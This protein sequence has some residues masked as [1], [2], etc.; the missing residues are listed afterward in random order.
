MSDTIETTWG[1]TL[2]GMAVLRLVLVLWTFRRLR[3][4]H[5]E[6]Y[7]AIGEPSLFGNNNLRTNWLFLKFLYLN[8][9]LDLNDWQLAC[10]ARFMQVMLVAYMIGFVGLL[11]IF[12]V[13]RL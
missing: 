4:H 10:V 3:L 6:T 8:Q 5:V 12:I 1:A 7:E 11:S 13:R 2:F 9:W